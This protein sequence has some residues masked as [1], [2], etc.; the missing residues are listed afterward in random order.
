MRTAMGGRRT[1][2]ALQVEVQRG[3]GLDADKL[4]K[5]EERELKYLG[6]VFLKGNWQIICLQG[7]DTEDLGMRRMLTAK[8]SRSK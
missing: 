6:I 5:N 4:R 7:D 8:R 2:V 3:E 1:G